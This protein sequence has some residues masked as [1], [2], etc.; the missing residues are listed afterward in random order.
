MKINKPKL[1]IDTDPGHDDALAI[2]MT[3]L[4]NKFDILAVTTVAGNATIKKV[5]RNAQAILNLIESDIP[6]FSGLPEP[7]KRE[8]V[9]AVVHGKSGLAGFDTTSTKFSLTNNAP[10]KLV[11]IVN[12]NPDEVTIL[13]LGPL[14]NVA[15]AI[16][17]DSTFVNKVKQF[18]IMGGAI[19]VPGNKNRVAEFNFFV[20]PEAADVVMRSNVPK[21]LVS[22]DACNQV[23][24]QVEDFR[25]VK[26]EK[27]Q[28]ILIPLMEHFF[29]GI[30]T[31]EGTKGILVYDALAAYF[32]LNP[33]AFKL[34]SMDVVIET[35]GE[36]TFGM[37]V[38][39]KRPHK[40]EQT[41]VEVVVKIDDQQF[42]K[43]FFEILN[44]RE[45]L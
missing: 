20:D 15:R 5:T 28:S 14:S 23:V 29:V 21:V 1:I 35:Q 41:N 16:N 25:Q 9:S 39:E 45:E 10:N 12:A 6:V 17:L 22:L 18:V 38:A 24:L 40:V 30:T 13:A 33:Q 2:L 3:V 19:D 11:E 4:S 42:R 37:C 8:F 31:Y 36:H 27:L 43:D 34:K 44:G 7:L 26:N 32:L